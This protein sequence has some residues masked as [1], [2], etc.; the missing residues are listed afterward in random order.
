MKGMIYTTK[1]DAESVNNRLTES[2]KNANIKNAIKKGFN[3]YSHVIKHNTDSKFALI[4]K[5]NGYYWSY[6]EQ[7]LT[8]NEKNSIVELTPDWFL[9]ID[10]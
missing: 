2:L 1:K 4:I 3:C 10:L 8:Q 5:D 7:E 9:T 6:I